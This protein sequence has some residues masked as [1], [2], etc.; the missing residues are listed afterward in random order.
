[1]EHFSFDARERKDRQVDDRDD[2]HAED[3]RLDHFTGR[4]GREAEAFVPGEQPPE[5]VLRLG[6]TPQAVLNDDDRTVDDQTEVQCAETHQVARDLVLDHA[7]DRHQHGQRDHGSRQ[8]RRPD[9][10]EQEEQNQDDEKRTFHEVLLNRLD[11]G[12]D[13]RRPV[14]DWRNRHA[15]RQA[16]PDRV[17]LLI[18][19]DG[20]GPA[21]LSNEHERG[22]QNNL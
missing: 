2:D 14:V 22:A 11:C 4:S 8:E 21:V 20:N 1:M 18:N 19:S 13:E 15:L 3:R 17:D 7:G 9:V 6:K 16:W 12:I 5:F 10:S